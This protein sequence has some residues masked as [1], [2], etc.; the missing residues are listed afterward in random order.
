ML[1]FSQADIIWFAVAQL[2]PPAAATSDPGRGGVTT[3]LAAPGVFQ[4]TAREPRP[5]AGKPAAMGVVVIAVL[6]WRAD[7]VI[8]V[9]DEHPLRGRCLR[10]GLHDRVQHRCHFDIFPEVHPFDCHRL[11]ATM[12]PP[13]TAFMRRCVETC[14]SWAYRCRCGHDDGRAVDRSAWRREFVDRGGP[15]LALLSVAVALRLIL[16]PWPGPLRL[17]SSTLSFRLSVA[18]LALNIVLNVLL[19]R[20]FG[21]VGAAAALVCTE[22]FGIVFATWWLHRPCGYRAP[23]VF[24]L[25]VLA[26]TAV[27]AAVV[28]LL[29][30]VHVLL[31]ILAAFVA[32][33]V[34][35]LVLGPVGWSTLSA[36]RRQRLMARELDRAYLPPASRHGG[37]PAHDAAVGGAYRHVQKP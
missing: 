18:T 3:H 30:G 5:A 26:P 1:V 15:T 12:P 24:L 28:V 27:S 9:A 16:A 10:A 6:Y 13:F 2:I 11:F 21:A 35:N 25:R 34:A 7:G 31:V 29:S 23:V 22:L 14:T 36:M 4:S 8:L 17:P 33:L 37:H 19:A 32:Y 20:Q